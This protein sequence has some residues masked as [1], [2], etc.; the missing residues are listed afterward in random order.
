[1]IKRTW[2]ILALAVI[3]VMSLVTYA[4][5]TQSFFSDNENSSDD[6]LGIRWGH[7]TINDG[8]ENTGSP[9]WDDKW[10]DNGVTDWRQDTRRTHTGTFDASSNRNNNGYLTSDDLDASTADN[11]TVLFYYNLSWLEAGDIYV[12]TFNGT[13]Y[14]NWFDLHTYNPRYRSGR[15]YQFREIITDPQYFIAGFRLRFDTTGL[16]E[17]FEEANIDDVIITTDTIPPN[18]PT[19]LIASGGPEQISLDWNDS[20]DEDI[21]TYNV[22]R[23]LTSS[24]NFTKINSSPVYGSYYVDSNLYGGGQY[25][26]MVTALDYG[27][28]ESGFSNEDND[29]AINA[30]PQAPTGLAVSGGG[31]AADI[32]WNP[33]VETDISYYDVYRDTGNGSGYVKINTG[34]PVYATNFTDILLYGGGTFS[35]RIKAT[36]NGSLTSGFSDVAIADVSNAPPSAPTGLA[37]TGFGE[38]IDL[39]WSANIETDVTAYKVFYGTSPS[40][41][42]PNDL[43]PTPISSTEYTH[44][45]IYGGG[46]RYYVIKAVDTGGLLSENSDEAGATATNVAPSPPSNLSAVGGAEYIDVSWTPGPETDVV[47][48]DIYRKP[49]GGSYSLLVSSWGAPTYTDSQLFGGGTYFYKVQAVDTGSL[50]SGDSNEGDATATD[51]LPSKPI[52]NSASGG[53]E[54]ITVYWT[55]NIDTDIAGYNVYRSDETGGPYTTKVNTILLTGN[56]TTDINLYGGGTYYYVV[57][58]VDT[59]NLSSVYSNEVS[60]TAIDVAPSMPSNLSATALGGEAQIFLDWDANIET[61]GIYYNVYRSTSTSGN[62]TQIASPIYTSNYTDFEAYGGIEY[63]YLVSAADSANNTSGFSNTDS[64]IPND[65]VP[66][67]TTGLVATPGD[68]L[69]YLSWDPTSINDFAGYNIYRRTQ[70]GNFTKI[71]SLWLTP[72]YTGT[73]LIGGQTYYFTVTVVDIGSNESANSNEASVTPVDNPPA[74]PTGLTAVRGG[75]KIYLDWDDNTE[76]D[77]AGY[78]LYRGETDGGPYPVKVNGATLIPAGTSEYLDTGLTA[79]ITYYYVVKAVDAGTNTSPVSSQA[80]A[81]PWA[82]Y[83]WRI[84]DQAEFENGV[85]TNVSTSLFP[86]SVVLDVAG[87]AGS[88]SM[89][90]LWDG[91]TAPAGWTIVSGP[92]DDF[93]Q[94]FPRGSDTYGATGGFATHTHNPSFSITSACNETVDIVAWMKAAAGPAHTHTIATGDVSEESHLPLYRDLQVIRY[95]NGV[96]TTIPAGAIA[97]FDTTPPSGW[98][99]YSDQDGYFVR[100]DAAAGVTGGNPTHSHVVNIVTD[101]PTDIVYLRRGGNAEYATDTHTHSAVASTDTVNN[102]PPYITVILA[103]ADVDTPV[104]AGMIAMFNATPSGNWDVVSGSGEPFY[105]SFIKGSSSYGTTGGSAIHSHG[106]QVVNLPE[107]SDTTRNGRDGMF[108]SPFA[109]HTHT[110]T[111]DV[112]S[113]DS[114]SNLPPYIDV[115]FA[116][117]LYYASGVIASDVEDTGY[118]GSEWTELQWDAVMPA[119]TNITFEVRASDTSFTKD[120]SVIPWLSVGGISPV[121][122]GLPS[123]R[124]KQWRAILTPNGTHTETPILQE[125]RAYLQYY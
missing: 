84:T 36:D 31:E 95:D 115:I 116:K 47:G 125:V 83:E 75:Q 48:W 120:D 114:V 28:N 49:D 108:F 97:I 93:Y 53:S 37:A 124:Y 25:F 112:T 113:Y 7:Y 79:D 51:A 27:N 72:N 22:Y 6:R 119:G 56:A 52:A 29:T 118:A 89:I 23:S 41:P 58:A 60:A 33:N 62:Y 13:H 123:G 90:L 104:P 55:A 59:G 63:F 77:L 110:H 9:P 87:S 102:D 45:Q 3:T 35:Y 14:I 71:E 10:D 64:A 20:T 86:G 74:A 117:V 111:V 76:S 67:A 98:T 4:G 85:Y 121:T 109:S 46:T 92:G 38:Y 21:W 40:G 18:N 8:F 32:S 80:S 81:T 103:K 26:Y 105:E 68:C 94:R 43:T 73:N 82:P 1:M 99:Q 16:T 69:A 24:V 50:R 42:Y 78:N 12:Q 106:D 57:Q 122:S 88:A 54:N 17:R 34:G 30:A 2:L 39:S 101:S 96:P 66:P 19:G 70:S 91:G 107:T 61:D 15:W 100:A 11:I 44:S 65:L 5:V